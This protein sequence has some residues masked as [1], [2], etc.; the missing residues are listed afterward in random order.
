M[1]GAAIKVG[2]PLPP[3]PEQPM[4]HYSHP[5][6][7]AREE[8]EHRERKA[9][10]ITQSSRGNS[11]G[12]D[13][14]PADA[15]RLI[16]TFGTVEPA[17]ANLMLIAVINATADGNP[18]RPPGC[19]RINGALAAISGIGAQDEIE[20]MLATQM[21]ATHIAATTVL[22]RLKGSETVLQQDSNGNLAV[23]LLRTFT[24]QVEALQRYRSKGQQKIVVE[25]VDVHAGGQAIV[26][27]VN[28]GGGC[29]EKSQKR[30]DAP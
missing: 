18:S 30:T 6:L 15:L 9:P 2:T 11:L 1:S 19:E 29:K 5:G 10:K 16:S 7:T 21:V 14:E 25:H 26:G 17:F 27:T 28:P 13:I 22:G 20:G 24:M 8:G 4:E 23:K 12:Y 3:A